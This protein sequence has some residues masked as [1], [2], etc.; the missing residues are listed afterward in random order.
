MKRS[1]QKIGKNK[2]SL[3]DFILLLSSKLIDIY[4]DFKDPFNLISSYYGYVKNE[5]NINFNKNNKYKS[6][7]KSYNNIISKLKKNKYLEEKENNLLP[8]KKAQIYL[9]INYP[10]FYFK[11]QNWDK[12]I[13]I[14][15]FDIYEINKYKRNCLRRLLKKLGFLM[16]QKSVWISPFNQFDIIKN[17]LKENSLKDNIIMIEAIKS[18]FKNINKIIN[19]FWID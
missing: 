6:K 12:K 8:T 10:Y 14:I 11:K 17:W 9:K 16:I 13:R 15:I 4:F 5:K 3:K 18:N 2:I 1:F 7:F 19:K